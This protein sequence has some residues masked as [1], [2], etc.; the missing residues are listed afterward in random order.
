M[1]CII[2]LTA[3]FLWVAWCQRGSCI[4]L[5][6]SCGCWFGYDKNTFYRSLDRIRMSVKTHGFCCWGYSHVA[7]DTTHRGAELSPV[8][9][10][11]VCAYISCHTANSLDF[12]IPAAVTMSTNPELNTLWTL[13]EFWMIWCLEKRLAHSCRASSRRSGSRGSD[14]LMSHN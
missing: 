1:L 7:A 11:H 9:K 6:A 4:L 12:L 2:I 3:L 5:A 13:G 14:T 10:K 8:R